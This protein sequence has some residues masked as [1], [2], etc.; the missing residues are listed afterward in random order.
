MKEWN[1]KIYETVIHST[2]VE[3]ANADEAYAKAYEIIANGP[4]SEY[5]TEA[6]GFTGDWS[7][8]EW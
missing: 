2:I 1:V 8:D 4:N 3:A 5:D 6:E 7:A